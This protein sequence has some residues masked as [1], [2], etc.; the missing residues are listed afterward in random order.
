M[1]ECT[2]LVG[3]GGDHAAACI[4]AQPCVLTRAIGARD[5]LVPPPAADHDRLA[6]QVGVAQQLDGRVERVHVEVGNEA[7]GWHGHEWIVGQYCGFEQLI[8]RARTHPGSRSGVAM[9]RDRL[10]RV[11]PRRAG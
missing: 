10:G 9:L 7:L 4:V 5:R 6:A 11:M 3:A 1:P 2:R 8:A